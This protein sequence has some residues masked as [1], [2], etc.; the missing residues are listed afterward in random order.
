MRDFME[1]GFNF[2]SDGKFYRYSTSIENSEVPGV[3]DP[4]GPIRSLD[5]PSKVVRGF[6]IY[7]CA[8][9]QRNE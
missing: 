2:F 8:I 1:K 9:M 4:D 3:Y 5:D 7:N 6:T